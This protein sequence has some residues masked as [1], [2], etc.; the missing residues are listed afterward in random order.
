V[1]YRPYWRYRRCAKTGEVPLA[2]PSYPLQQR[3]L[4]Y[5]SAVSLPRLTYAHN[6]A[7]LFL[8][9]ARDMD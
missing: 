5:R 2:A 6:V 9:S 1:R 8:A 7:I 3:V 4:T